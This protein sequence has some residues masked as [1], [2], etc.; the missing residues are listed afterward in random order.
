MK[1]LITIL[2]AY[3]PVWQASFAL[4]SSFFLLPSCTE[5]GVFEK[6]ILIPGHKWDSA[7]KPFIDF[8]ITDTSSQYN[9]FLVV[10]HTDAYNFNNI[11]VRIY[12]KSPGDS[13]AAVQQ[14][15]LPLASQNQ[16]TGTGMDDIFEHRLMLY[17]K[18]VKFKHSGSYSVTIEQVMREN[19]L[20]YV[21]NVGLRVEKVY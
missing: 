21:M 15:D 9:I 5:V 13:M 2:T 17:N 20:Q 10:R 6:N 18:P 3:L 4:L 11:W 7:F 14:F 8:E 12:S 19:P 1:R 16:W